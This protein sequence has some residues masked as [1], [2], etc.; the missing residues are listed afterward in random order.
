VYRACK[1][2]S[3]IHG[4]RGVW[5]ARKRHPPSPH[6]PMAAV[7]HD[8]LST[9][10]SMAMRN[11]TKYS[12]GTARACT[13]ISCP[14]SHASRPPPG[15]HDPRSSYASPAALWPM[16]S[17][18]KRARS[19]PLAAIGVDPD[20]SS[21]V[22]SIGAPADYRRPCDRLRARVDLV[23]ASGAAEESPAVIRRDHLSTIHNLRAAGGVSESMMKTQCGERVAA[24]SRC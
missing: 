14:C 13:M 10:T 12:Q 15:S 1:R 20:Q 24:A 5:A 8:P 22:P 16:K 9:C 3:A 17:R 21:S 11:L 6:M 4:S 2:H 23:R 18:P 7:G 19:A